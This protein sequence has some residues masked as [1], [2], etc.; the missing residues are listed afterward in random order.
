MTL[1]DIPLFLQSLTDREKTIFYEIVNISLKNT[2][3]LT[4]RE[5]RIRKKEIQVE[6]TKLL[7]SSDEEHSFIA[8]QI[9]IL[10]L[11]P[12]Y[13]LYIEELGVEAWKKYLSIAQIFK[14]QTNSLSNIEISVE[15]AS[16]V[17]IGKFSGFWY[18]N[19]A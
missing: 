8:E 7:N 16:R 5:E 19:F 3:I 14:N 17:D 2:E 15:K 18:W 11:P 12:P 1:K 13:N 10:K 4:S 6:I 9:L